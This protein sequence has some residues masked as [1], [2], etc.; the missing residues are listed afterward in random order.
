MSMADPLR[1]RNF[2]M[3]CAALMS[4]EV[5]PFYFPLIDEPIPPSIR[6]LQQWIEIAWDDGVCSI[7]LLSPILTPFCVGFDLEG[8]LQLKKLSGTNKWIGTAD[9]WVAF[10]SRR[11]PAELVDF[12]VTKPSGVQPLI[13]WTIRYFT[14][15]LKRNEGPQSAFDALKSS[16]SV[17]V[18][19]MLPFILQ[20]SGHS[21]L[22]VGY[23]ITKQ[24]KVNLLTFDSSQYVISLLGI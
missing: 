20:H 14:P 6:G 5:Q 9:I 7:R 3:I 15:K 16:N 23:E 18:T 12:D 22:I 24:G 17:V 8:K 19:D 4:Q 10:S 1:Y 11:I 21:R 2:L 13:D